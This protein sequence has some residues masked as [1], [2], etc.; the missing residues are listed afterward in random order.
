MCVEHADALLASRFHCAKERGDRQSPLSM[1][2]EAVPFSNH[3]MAQVVV[4]GPQRNGISKT[5]SMNGI[6]VWRGR[7]HRVAILLAL[8]F[9]L[10]SKA[11]ATEE[12]EGR[13]V[14]LSWEVQSRGACE[15][16]NFDG[17][18]EA[19]VSSPEVRL[20]RTAKFVELRSMRNP[21]LI[22]GKSDGTQYQH[23]FNISLSDYYYTDTVSMN[24]WKLGTLDWYEDVSVRIKRMPGGNYRIDYSKAVFR[25]DGEG[26]SKTFIRNYGP[27]RAYVFEMRDGC[28][29]LTQ[30]LR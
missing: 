3:A 15:D 4:S 6:T 8:T 2:T 13:I 12:V 1:L 26:D 18:F 28:W 23:S 16:K 22:A 24:K 9:I 27:K 29:K 14:D 7:T 19:F 21:S 5:R 30:D 25:D 20:E 11:H 10:Q 17:F